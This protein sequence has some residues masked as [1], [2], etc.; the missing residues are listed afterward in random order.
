M[1]DLVKSV[2]EIVTPHTEAQ[3]RHA[4]RLHAELSITPCSPRCA[5]WLLYGIQPPGHYLALPARAL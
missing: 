5:V 4:E 2:S 3:H 1:V